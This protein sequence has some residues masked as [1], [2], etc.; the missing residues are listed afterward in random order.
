MFLD[1][2]DTGAILNQ[3]DHRLL[4]DALARKGN[5]GLRF[6]DPYKCS[7]CQKSVLHRRALETHLEV[8]HLRKSKFC[9]DLCP[10]VYFSR[11]AI[12]WHMKRIHWQ[13]KFACDV[14]S[15]S[16]GQKSHLRNHKLRHGTKV[17]CPTCKKEVTSLKSHMKYHKPKEA[18]PICNRKYW[19]YHLKAHLNVHARDINKNRICPTVTALAKKGN[20]GKRW[21]DSHICCICGKVTIRLGELKKHIGKYH[22]QSTKWF[23]DLCPMIFY[24][25]DEIWRHMKSKHCKPAFECS[26]CDYKTSYH[27]NYELHKLNHGKKVEC[28]I[29]KKYVL[30]LKQHMQYHGPKQKCSVCHGMYKPLGL[31][32]HMRTHENCP[33]CEICN[34]VFIRKKDFKM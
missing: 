25:R 5:E 23:C 10:R 26:V 32:E 31:K 2:V 16:T 24:N 30:K 13:K 21:S 6:K 28:P 4:I 29:C 34:M 19:K 22:C 20:E 9:C 3:S 7:L 27:T 1:R 15:Y 12:S 14:C 18:C 8:K 11:E 33:K 17:Q